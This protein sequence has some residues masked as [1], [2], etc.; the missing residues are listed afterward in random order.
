MS[1]N[2][3][4]EKDQFSSAKSLTAVKFYVYLY[5]GCLST[6]VYF[7][8]YLGRLYIVLPTNILVYV[9]VS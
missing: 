7:T 6:H 3:G 9:R 1:G 2:L 8:S 5:D 4:P